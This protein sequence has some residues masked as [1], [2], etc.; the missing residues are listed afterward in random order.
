MIRP[1]FDA[2]GVGCK[3]VVG[4]LFSRGQINKPILTHSKKTRASGNVAE[5]LASKFVYVSFLRKTL[6][7]VGGTNLVS[8]L[9][10]ES[11]EPACFALEMDTISYHMDFF[12]FF[13]FAF[14]FLC[15]ISF[16]F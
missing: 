12:L 4:A 8:A 6:N 9:C 3:C 2:W 11:S 1:N 7:V 10:S 14:S 16:C 13:S 15:F 5:S